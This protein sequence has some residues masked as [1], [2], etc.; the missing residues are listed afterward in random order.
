MEHGGKRMESGVSPARDGPPRPS[1]IFF[2]RPIPLL[3]VSLQANSYKKRCD[4]I[5]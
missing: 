5:C 1:L 3:G 4:G 2:L